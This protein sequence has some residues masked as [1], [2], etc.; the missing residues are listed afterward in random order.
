[1]KMQV[2][3]L[4]LLSG[5]RIQHCHE[6]WCR[7]QMW[8]VSAVVVAVA[9]ACSYS[10]DL[11]PSQGTAICHRYGPKKQKKKVVLLVLFLSALVI[12]K[13][14]TSYLILQ[15]LPLSNTLL[16]TLYS[17]LLYKNKV[18]ISSQN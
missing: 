13:L 4:A 2:P 7:S 17:L 1:M 6:L 9:V 10:S 5:L 3:S 12:S 16:L 8:L 11:T 14:I 15:C 18:Q